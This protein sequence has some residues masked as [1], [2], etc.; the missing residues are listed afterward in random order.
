M[1]QKT[2]K[3]YTP[4]HIT[5]VRLEDKPVVTQTACKDSTDTDACAQI[6][7][8]DLGFEVKRLPAFD[9]SPS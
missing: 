6:I 4:P 7:T 2:R 8:D 5:Q 9:I 3:P 1:D